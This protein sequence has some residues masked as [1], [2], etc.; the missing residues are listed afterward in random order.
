M[1][2]KRRISVVRASQ[3]L[4]R[5][6]IKRGWT[7]TV[8]WVTDHF[9]THLNEDDVAVA[10]SAGRLE[11]LQY[12]V[13][14]LGMRVTGVCFSWATVAGHVQVVQYLLQQTDGSQYTQRVASNVRK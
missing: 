3:A 8:R 7:R 10:A 1:A 14:E 13:A 12:L 9:P 6:A 2:E 11:V 4:V 5:Y